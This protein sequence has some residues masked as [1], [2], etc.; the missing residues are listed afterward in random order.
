[1]HL[2]MYALINCC[3]F[4]VCADSLSRQQIVSDLFSYSY[5]IRKS[6]IQHRH[7]AIIIIIIIIIINLNSQRFSWISKSSGH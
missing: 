7:V 2:C 6:F 5:N 4:I 1:M 3:V